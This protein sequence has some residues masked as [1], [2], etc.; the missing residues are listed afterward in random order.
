MGPDKK[1]PRL[2]SSTAYLESEPFSR[3]FMGFLSFYFFPPT[4]LAGELSIFFKL[5]ITVY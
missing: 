5:K 4:F 2:D 3:N 1:V